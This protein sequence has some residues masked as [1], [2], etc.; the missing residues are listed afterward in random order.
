LKFKSREGSVW[1]SIEYPV[2]HMKMKYSGDLF[3]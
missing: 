1:Y 2:L 3:M